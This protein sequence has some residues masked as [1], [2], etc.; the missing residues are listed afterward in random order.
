MHLCGLQ[1][2]DE[3]AL[4][5]KG[6]AKTGASQFEGSHGLAELAKV[7]KEVRRECVLFDVRWAAP[8]ACARAFARRLDHTIV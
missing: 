7:F 1:T 8:H 2:I 6:G 3:M 5:Q 4:Q